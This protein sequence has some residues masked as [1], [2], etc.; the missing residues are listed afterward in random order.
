MRFQKTF[1]CMFLT[2]FICAVIVICSEGTLRRSRCTVRNDED[3]SAFFRYYGYRIVLPAKSVSY[4]TIP[5]DF[6]P[7]YYKYN[8]IQQQAGFNLRLYCGKTV[9][10]RTYIIDTLTGSHNI[11]GNILILGGRII[12]GDVTDCSDAGFIHPLE[13]SD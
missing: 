11:V 10:K 7:D 5:Y 3:I 12:G 6:D 9:E 4:I 1:I 8:L 2:V 13:G